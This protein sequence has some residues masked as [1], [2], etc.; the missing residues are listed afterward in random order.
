M[1]LS[2]VLYTGNGTNTNFVVPFEYLHQDHIKVSVGGVQ[3][4]SFTW[5]SPTIINITPAPAQG[6]EVML[7][8]ETPADEPIVTYVSPHFAMQELNMATKQQ[9][10]ITQ[11]ILDDLV[12]Y[13]DDNETISDQI[14]TALQRAEEI[15]L[16]TANLTN[17]KYNS[18]P[19]T[20]KR[21]DIVF[22]ANPYPGG[23]VGW[24]CVDTNSWRGFGLIQS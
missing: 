19:P 2:R 16:L 15:T 7:F 5:S 1:F 21:G 20:G 12:M 23:Y 3:T 13:L 22:C 4:S 9:L 18:P 8:R 14:E 10:F 17:A 6:V 24:V 11:E